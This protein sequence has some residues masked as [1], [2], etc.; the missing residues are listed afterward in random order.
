MKGYSYTLFQ[1][2][3]TRRGRLGCWVCDHLAAATDPRWQSSTARQND[4]ARCRQVGGPM[5]AHHVVAKQR[6]KAAFP[7]GGEVSWLETEKGHA[8]LLP[9]RLGGEDAVWLELGE[10]L[11]DERNGLPVRR[12]HHDMLEQAAVRFAERAWPERVRD[13]A[14]EHGFVW[15]DRKGYVHAELEDL[16]A[17]G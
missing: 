9:R 5:D 13:F 6:I 7:H 14:A 3:V 10:L 8:I 12:Y 1:E 4:V 11:M 15:D 17:A 2:R 16:R